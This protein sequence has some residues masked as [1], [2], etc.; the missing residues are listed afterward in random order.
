V[1]NQHVYLYYRFQGYIA[2]YHTFRQM[3]ATFCYQWAEDE[4]EA[5]QKDNS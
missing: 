4:K 5:Q 1:K 3:R 2:K